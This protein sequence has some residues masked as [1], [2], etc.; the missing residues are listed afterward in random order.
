MKNFIQSFINITKILVNLYMII[1]KN[2]KKIE[3]RV[4]NQKFFYSNIRVNYYV[5]NLFSLDFFKK[6]NIFLYCVK[7]IISQVYSSIVVLK[8]IVQKNDIKKNL[9]FSNNKKFSK[10]D[11]VNIISGGNKQIIENH[12]LE[13][14][15]LTLTRNHPAFMEIVINDKIDYSLAIGNFT[16][17]NNNSILLAQGGD[18]HQNEVYIYNNIELEK[19]NEEKLK[20]LEEILKRLKDVNY[21][22]KIQISNKYSNNINNFIEKEIKQ[23]IFLK[24]EQIGIEGKIERIKNCIDLEEKMNSRED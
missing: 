20:E 15:I 11:L 14:K 2:K 7:K 10:N 3:N 5:L 17:S 12:L 19:L 8:K 18:L 22:K 24:N 21:T 23:Q 6:I 16:T 1:S 9:N 4:I 13:Y